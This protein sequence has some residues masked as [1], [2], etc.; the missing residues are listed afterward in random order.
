MLHEEDTVGTNMRP[1][2]GQPI[3]AT[4]DAAADRRRNWGRWGPDDH[5]GTLNHATVQ[6]IIRAAGLV[7]KGQVVSWMAG[8][9]W[10][11]GRLAWT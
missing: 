3:R 11:R 9:S 8:R 1:G 5:V 7:G 2:M 10:R 6:D 4:L